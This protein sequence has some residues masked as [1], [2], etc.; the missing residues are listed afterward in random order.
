MTK[1]IKPLTEDELINALYQGQLEPY[2]FFS[3]LEALRI[4]LGVLSASLDI[5]IGE[6]GLRPV[7]I[8]Y[9]TSER[10]TAAERRQLLDAGEQLWSMYPR[11]KPLFP[12]DIYLLDQIVSK[13]EWQENTYIQ[14]L[15]KPFGI[16]N[17]L[18]MAVSG[19]DS[20]MCLLRLALDGTFVLDESRVKFLKQLQ[21]HLER[22]LH[23]HKR[24]RRPVPIINAYESMSDRLNIGLFIL[25]GHGKVIQSNKAGQSIVRRNIGIGLSDE[26]IVFPNDRQATQTFKQLFSKAIAWR[27]EMF[28]AWAESGYSLEAFP[29]GEEP[30]DVLRLQREQAAYLD[31]LFQ[32]LK[33]FYAY[34]NESGPHVIVYMVDSE[35]LLSAPEHLVMELY[36][37][38]A[39]E[40]RFSLLLANGYSINAIAQTL[41]LTLGS[42]RSYSKTIY[43]KTGVSRQAELTEL[44]LKSVVL[45]ANEQTS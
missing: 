1:N 7:T 41:N 24:I 14:T 45:L 20:V 2:P 13:A 15:L 8:G 22:A 31:I 3:F 9:G 19:P 4:R 33:P 16:D 37:L 43:S 27:N 23:M 11:K 32:P 10:T 30:A 35:R 5:G 26:H 25:N 28:S 29:D 36:G 18:V 40:A 17:E 38:T 34:H 42:A 44:L 39:A 6:D 12:G 21:P